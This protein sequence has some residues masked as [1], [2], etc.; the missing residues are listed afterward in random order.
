MFVTA[1]FFRLQTFNF[2]TE[3]TMTKTN[4]FFESKQAY[5]AFRAAFAAAQNNLRS[6]KGKPDSNGV[7]ASGWLSPS[8]YM[9]LNLARGL[10]YDRGFTPVTNQIALASGCKP[11]E[12]RDNARKY[13]ERMIAHATSYLNPKDIERSWRFPKTMSQAEIN[14][15][16]Q[17]ELLVTIRGFLEPIEDAFTI[18]D[19]A[20]LKF[21]E[22][23][24]S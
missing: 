21:S 13:L 8:H 22:G 23:V 12:A 15:K 9:L 10:P 4:K 5:L 17:A 16:H 19:L 24:T 20:N 14:A 7:R 2:I 6:K 11:D 3:T 1:I 18:N